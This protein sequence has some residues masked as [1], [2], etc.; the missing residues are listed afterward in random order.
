MY[1]VPENPLYDNFM[2]VSNID[3]MTVHTTHHHPT[4]T[5]CQ[6]YLSCY[7]PDFDQTLKVESWET[8][9]NWFQLSWRHLSR[10]QLSWQH[11]SISEIFQL[12]LTQGNL[13][14]YAKSILQTGNRCT[15]FRLTWDEF[16]TN[17][18]LISIF[19]YFLNFLQKV[20]EF[21][22]QI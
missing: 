19:F 20:Q 22:F 3:M 21:Y 15:N 10:Q 5:Q 2:Q 8:I 7:W 17:L 18:Q 1:T 11:L 16:K 12:L 9:L 14:F 13:F 4:Q 6:Q